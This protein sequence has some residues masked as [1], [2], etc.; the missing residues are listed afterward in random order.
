M[1]TRAVDGRTRVICLRRFIF[2]QSRAGVQSAEVPPEPHVRGAG[3]GAGGRA[4]GGAVGRAAGTDRRARLAQRAGR[5]RHALR[6]RRAAALLWSVAL[7]CGGALIDPTDEP[8]HQ[9]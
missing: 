2:R 7:S 1:L 8:S 9:Y 3:V 5:A 6:H 4:A